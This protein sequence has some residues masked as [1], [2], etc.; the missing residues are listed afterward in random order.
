M[1]MISDAYKMDNVFFVPE[2]ARW[3][4]IASAAHTPEIGTV[5]DNAMRAIEAENK[6]LKECTCRK[7]TQAQIW[8][9]EF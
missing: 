7:I 9:N 3:N 4:N 5:I 8:I 6:K 1:K 2:E